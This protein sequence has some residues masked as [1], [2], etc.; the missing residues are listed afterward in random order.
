VRHAGRAGALLRDLTTTP[1]DHFASDLGILP[2]LL[3]DLVEA[4]SEA[5]PASRV[6]TKGLPEPIFDIVRGSADVRG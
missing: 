3:A 2:A 5:M 1:H 4:T 6:T